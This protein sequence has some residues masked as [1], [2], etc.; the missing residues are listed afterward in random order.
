[1]VA[2]HT[3]L[4][5]PEGILGAVASLILLVVKSASWTFLAQ[6]S[7]AIVISVIWALYA[8]SLVKQRLGTGAI[9]TLFGQRVVGLMLRT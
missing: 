3:L 5:I 1:M 2:L 6:E 8:S 4:F 7:S 9:I